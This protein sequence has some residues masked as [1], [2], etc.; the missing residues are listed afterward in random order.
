MLFVLNRK[1][2][3]CYH[4]IILV[5]CLCSLP[6]AN[7]DNENLAIHG[8]IAQGLIQSKD[9][10]FVNDDNDFSL[11][12][13][14]VGINASY[15]LS[16]KFRV[17]GQAVYLNGGNRFPEGPRIDYLLLDW[18][19][20]TS[21]YWQT[22][23]Y[24]G[25]FKNYHWLY[26]STRD[27]PI[28]RPSIILPQSVYFD[29]TRDMSVGGDGV[30]ITSKYS[31]ERF[32]DFDVNFSSGTTPLNKENVR[33]LLGDFATG[34]M[35]YNRDLQYS[36]YWQPIS[37]PLRFGAA[38]TSGDFDYNAGENDAFNSGKV[39]INR[40]YLNA[41]YH[42]EKWLLS[43]ELLHEKLELNNIY[44][45]GFYRKTVGEGGFVQANYQLNK[46]IKFLVKYERY[47]ANK[48]DKNG[49]LLQQASF[50]TVP[51]YFAY[52]HD[53]TLGLSYSLADHFVIQL[54]HHWYDGT[55]RLMPLF[56]P[57][58]AVNNKAKWQLSALQ[59]IYWF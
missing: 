38:F 58:P 19:A 55:A 28:N 36:L 23:I 15:Q 39:K 8:F 33:A 49:A 40:Y 59:F 17:A 3:S 2:I 14:E 16:D 22:N 53:V 26:S 18:S 51:R 43:A 21:N 47:F 32:G 29:G 4:F 27:V 7:A 6:R 44:Y 34:K 24:L 25:R 54:E 13:T 56:T 1:T 37:L 46:D 41:E 30:A 10:D 50:G 5:L 48:R 11:K 9:S 20:Y 12:L 42:G 52:Q 57:N 35:D 45:P 31:N